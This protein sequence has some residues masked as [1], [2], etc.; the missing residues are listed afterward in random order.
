M[1]VNGMKINPYKYPFIVVE[2]IDGC[3][4]STLIESLQKWDKQNKIGA[5]FTKEPT[6]GSLGKTIRE[7][8]ANDG[9]SSRGAKIDPKD[10]QTFYIKDRF[11]HRRM[12]SVFLGKYPIFSD[13]DFF[14]TITYGLA[15]HIDLHFLLRKHEEILGNY[16]FVPDLVIILDLPA[17]E[18]IK[19]IEKAGK[20]ADFFEKLKFLKLVRDAYLAFPRLIDEIYPDVELPCAVIR[21]SQPPEKVLEESLFWIDKTFQE[22]LE[23]TEYIK[24]FKKKED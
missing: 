22:K 19:R 20:E 16:F 11:G 24:I 10:L 15:A 12:E 7:I 8:L 18:A 3:G 17:E 21:A 23:A 13:R 5:I 2:G 9:Q 14:S 4:K 6:D 1:V